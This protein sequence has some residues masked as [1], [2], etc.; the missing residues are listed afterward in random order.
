MFQFLLILCRHAAFR[1]AC[2]VMWIEKKL[3]RSFNSI[4]IKFWPLTFPSSISSISLISGF[5]NFWQNFSRLTFHS[6]CFP[7]NTPRASRFS[8]SHVRTSLQSFCRISLMS[9]ASSRVFSRFSWP[10]LSLSV[11]LSSWS[12]TYSKVHKI[13]R[14]NI[15]C[16]FQKP[17]FPNLNWAHSR[18]VEV[19]YYSFGEFFTVAFI[20]NICNS[21]WIELMRHKVLVY[22]ASHLWNRT[23]SSIGKF[24]VNFD[25]PVKRFMLCNRVSN[26]SPDRAHES[27][28]R[29]LT[30]IAIFEHLVN[31]FFNSL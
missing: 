5:F 3:L 30:K 26:I 21:D 19:I 14:Y 31:L 1:E 16:T 12:A 7:W 25:S 15:W 8:S 6:S 10:I 28:Q 4:F 23:K 13:S 22:Q 9:F 29:L 11:S 18:T 20:E 27:F 17:L 2:K 24:L